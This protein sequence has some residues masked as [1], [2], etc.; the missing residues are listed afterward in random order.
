MTEPMGRRIYYARCWEGRQSLAA[1]GAAVALKEGRTKPY[2]AATVSDWEHNRK[3]PSVKAL[4]AAAA[5]GHVRDE[6]LIFGRGE[7]SAGAY[8]AQGAA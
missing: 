8:T 7:R 4:I 2:S 3:V 5:V 1:F 6:W